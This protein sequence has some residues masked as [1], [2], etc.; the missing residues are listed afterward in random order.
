MNDEDGDDDDVD[1]DDDDDDD[2]GGV[3]D[4]HGEGLPGPNMHAT[5]IYPC[6]VSRSKHHQS[7]S[8]GSMSVEKVSVSICLPTLSR[9]LK[10]SPAKYFTPPWHAPPPHTLQTV[11]A[12]H[13]NH[14][15]AVLQEFPPTPVKCEPV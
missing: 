5:M 1:D 6:T 12:F 7:P 3:D 15:T 11:V 14:L 4:D 8:S 10:H 9:V 2:G 13:R